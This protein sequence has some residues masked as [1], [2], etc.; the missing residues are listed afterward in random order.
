MHHTTYDNGRQYERFYLHDTQIHSKVYSSKNSRIHNLSIEF[1]WFA[2]SDFLF[3]CSLGYSMRVWPFSSRSTMFRT[4][5]IVDVVSVL[6]V[7]Y[8]CATI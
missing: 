1:V 7:V 3:R 8:A 5:S 6:N 2:G 4:I